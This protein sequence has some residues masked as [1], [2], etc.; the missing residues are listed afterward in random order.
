L[1]GTDLELD[2][3]NT[4]NDSEI[5]KEAEERKLHIM[6]KV[7]DFLEIW[8]GSQS[9]RATQTESHTQNK[10]ITAVGYNSVTEEIVKASWSLFQHDCAAAFKLSE[11]SPLPP[12]LS[13]KDLP[14]G[15]S[16]ILNVCQFRRINHHTV[17]SDKDSAPESISDTEDWL[18]WNGDLDNPN[19]TKEDCAVD[20]ESDIEPN[21]GIEN[22]DCS[23]R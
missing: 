5:K 1:A 20:D 9:L 3:T 23:E 4:E 17:E 16:Q 10:Q 22:L 15:R 7:H 6:D 21:N 19:V 12:A 2:T 11:R 14:G 13:A 8:H 18:N